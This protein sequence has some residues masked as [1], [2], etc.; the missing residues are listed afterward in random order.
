MSFNSER[1]SSL[2]IVLV[3]VAIM[4]I[5]A[6]TL[7]SVVDFNTKTV[8]N[9]SNHET[10][11]HIAEAGYNKYLYML[12]NNT[13]FYK[14]GENQQE[15]FIIK[16][17]YKSSDNPE[18][19]GYVKA[20]EPVAYE[21]GNKII[22]YYQI[23]ITPPTA[24]TPVLGIQSTGWTDNKE[25]KR[26]IYVEVHKRTFTDYVLFENNEHE[27]VPFSSDSKIKGPYFTNGDLYALAGAE[28][29]DDVGYVG[30]NR[31]SG[32][33]F[34]KEGQPV[35]M[36]PMGLPTINENLTKWG[37]TENGGYTYNKETYI[38]LNED[39]MN[40]RLKGEERQTDVPYPKSGV[41][42]V[43]GDVYISG[44]LD[45]RLT[46]IAEKNIY[47]CAKDPTIEVS[48]QRDYNQ[49]YNYRGITYKNQ[50]I[51]VYNKK[52]VPNSS[53]DMLGLVAKENIIIHNR[54][55]KWPQATKGN[56]NTTVENIQVQAALY[57]NSVT[58]QDLDYISYKD[59]GQIKYLGS[60]V[61][62]QDGA[63]GITSMGR[64]YGYS[65]DNLY[66]YRMQYEAPPHFV[67]PTNAGWEVVTW[68]EVHNN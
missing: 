24:D 38:L 33:I 41:I 43:N 16:E 10:A 1:G 20:Y 36:N 48:T 63:T 35:K 19:D 31:A 47:I 2:P 53:D 42:Y 45:G 22:G 46:I 6:V 12:N 52:D 21:S 66:D 25:A 13:Y 29:F 28:F 67:E 64:N 51:P 49:L 58:V 11:L 40:V 44:V 54:T 17:R 18:W 57:C 60:R 14:D 56:I 15:G 8:L 39:R 68:K 65:S 5:L 26:T 9:I 62:K 4:L 50:N 55:H 59:W 30:R 32:A 3:L 34:R 7:V 27:S 61:V 23:T 37:R